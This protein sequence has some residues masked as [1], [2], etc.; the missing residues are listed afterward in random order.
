VIF[1]EN[2]CWEVLRNENL[3]MRII[4]RHSAFNQD[5]SSHATNVVAD[6]IGII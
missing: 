2:M 4:S 5:S 3:E 1:I 6:V